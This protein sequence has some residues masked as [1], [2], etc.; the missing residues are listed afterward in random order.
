[1]DQGKI[2]FIRCQLVDEWEDDG[3][4]MTSLIS[5]FPPFVADLVDGQR[6][7]R[8][9]F[10]HDGFQGRL[11][12]FVGRFPLLS[13]GLASEREKENGGRRR[14]NRR[15]KEIKGKL[16]SLLVSDVI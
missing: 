6:R 11:P 15:R 8:P 13:F 9:Q 14:R 3:Q 2:S 5:K 12:L 10:Q 4:E 16:D 7:A 1:M